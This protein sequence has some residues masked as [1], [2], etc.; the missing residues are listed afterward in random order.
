MSSQVS[1][2]RG[3]PSQKTFHAFL[4]QLRQVRDLLVGE[5]GLLECAGQR[6]HHFPLR[7]RCG[8]RGE[9]FCCTRPRGHRG[10]H[11][12]CGTMS[13]NLEVWK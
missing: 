3:N 9:S 1:D 7:E 12:S 10:N 13:H 8:E 4:S 5:V 11:I 6:T 2:V